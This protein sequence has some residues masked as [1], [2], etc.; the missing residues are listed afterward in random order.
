MPATNTKRQDVR[1]QSPPLQAAYVLRMIN[2][3]TVVR[4]EPLPLKLDDASPPDRM[5][6]ASN[7]FDRDQHS[8]SYVKIRPR[9]KHDKKQKYSHSCGNSPILL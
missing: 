2:M 1:S 4:F 3:Y 9:T 8:N 6:L 5:R 7:A